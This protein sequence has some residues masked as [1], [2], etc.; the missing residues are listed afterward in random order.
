M[1]PAGLSVWLCCVVVRTGRIDTNGDLEVWFRKKQKKRVSI[2]KTTEKSFT[3]SESSMAAN[4]P[5]GSLPAPL[6]NTNTYIH[7]RSTNVGPSCP[8]ARARLKTPGTECRHAM[9]HERAQKQSSCHGIALLVNVGP[10]CQSCSCARSK[11][12]TQGTVSTVSM[13]KEK[14][15]GPWGTIH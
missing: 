2:K 11:P 14:G 7:V 15:A 12:A 9:L 5:Q 6:A 8:A 10:S 1:G 3:H 13:I 4:S